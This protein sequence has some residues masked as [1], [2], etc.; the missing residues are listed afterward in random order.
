MPPVGVVESRRRGRSGHRPFVDSRTSGC[1]A[2]EREA[3]ST[4]MRDLLMICTDE[5]AL[6]A[7]PAE[8]SAASMEE[9]AA[10]IDAMNARGILQGAERLRPTSDATTVRVRRGE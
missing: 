2:R 7:R 10:L 4:A 3:R 8:E 9:Y 5:E 6:L 1:T